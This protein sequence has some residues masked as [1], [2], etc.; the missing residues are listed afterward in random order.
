MANE[1]STK[2]LQN[3]IYNV[4]G[5][6]NS[7]LLV[8]ASLALAGTYLNRVQNGTYLFEPNKI[9]RPI[10]ADK[11]TGKGDKQ[12]T[13]TAADQLEKFEKKITELQ[14]A[15]G[16]VNNGDGTFT[17]P[18]VLVSQGN[19]YDAYA[20]A[21]GL[22]RK[23]IFPKLDSQSL[24]KYALQAVDALHLQ[25]SSDD[26]TVSA[27]ATAALALLREFDA[28]AAAT[29]AERQRIAK[30]VKARAAAVDAGIDGDAFDK[31]AGFTGAA[32]VAPTTAIEPS[33]VGTELSEP[34]EPS[35]VSP[36]EVEAP[37]HGKGK[38]R[39]HEAVTA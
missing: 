14:N 11:V 25:A 36:V 38:N 8:V 20:N 34:T 19:G 13:V 27:D 4:A 7:G 16:V 37:K 2:R 39:K 5:D 23:D 10:F 3:A 26:A 35:E 24:L 6:P 33:E 15:E 21:E 32:I 18:E 29:I 17:V 30:H 1:T 28:S 12:K 31:L 9:V 22:L